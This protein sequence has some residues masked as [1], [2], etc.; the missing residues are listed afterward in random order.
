MGNRT[1]MDA[2]DVRRGHGRGKEEVI[3]DDLESAEE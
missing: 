1:K 2:A 3:K